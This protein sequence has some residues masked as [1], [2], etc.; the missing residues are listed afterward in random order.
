MTT[1]IAHMRALYRLQAMKTP[2]LSAQVLR[3]LV[4]LLAVPCAAQAQTGAAHHVE[5][6]GFGSYTRYDDTTA[7]AGRS[8]AGGRLGFYFSR[9]L[10]LEATGDYAVTQLPAGADVSVSRVGGN[11]LFHARAMGLYLGAGYERLY[12]R[13]AQVAEP[14]GGQ[15]ILQGTLSAKRM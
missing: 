4:P 1:P 14:S 2:S 9:L 8:G 13:G 15:I 3:A 10:S 7:L 6:G 5:L 12:Q 11:L